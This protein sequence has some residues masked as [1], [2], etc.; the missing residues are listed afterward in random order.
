MKTGNFKQG[1]VVH[2]EPLD[3]HSGSLNHRRVW[4][5]MTLALYD[6]QTEAGMLW[7]QALLYKIGMAR[8]VK[9]G[10]SA[11]QFASPGKMAPA[12]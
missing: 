9:K 8:A 3:F 6:P 11:V 2:P 1:P 12:A 10:S 4:P 7:K 5:F